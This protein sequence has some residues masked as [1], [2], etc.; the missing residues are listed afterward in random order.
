MKAFL[1][2]LTDLLITICLIVLFFNIARSILK[3]TE[4]TDQPAPVTQSK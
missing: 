1:S 4:A 2:V 3:P